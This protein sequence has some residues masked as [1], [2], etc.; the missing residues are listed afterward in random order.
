MRSR[1]FVGSLV[2]AV[3]IALIA[4]EEWAYRSGRNTFPVDLST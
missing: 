2:L 4:Y 1:S 3:L